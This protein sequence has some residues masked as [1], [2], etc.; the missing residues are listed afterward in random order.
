MERLQEFAKTAPFPTTWR[1]TCECLGVGVV[2]CDVVQ[3]ICHLLR[4][5]V[6]PCGALFLHHDA[7]CGG[8]MAVYRFK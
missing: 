6:L 3:M 5:M 7:V 1:T 8:L 4:R 2:A